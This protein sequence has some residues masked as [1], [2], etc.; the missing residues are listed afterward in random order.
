MGFKAPRAWSH[1]TTEVGGYGD[2]ARGVFSR[3]GFWSSPIGTAGCKSCWVPDLESWNA[4]VTLDLAALAM[5]ALAAL[6][7]TE[8]L[9][10]LP[11]SSFSLLGGKPKAPVSIDDDAFLDHLENG[12]LRESVTQECLTPRPA[13]HWGEY[14]L[15]RIG[16]DQFKYGSSN[17][18]ACCWSGPWLVRGHRPACDACYPAT[19]HL[20]SEHTHTL[21]TECTRRRRTRRARWRSASS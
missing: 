13:K 3:V 7:V 21:T 4:A 11:P 15:K 17:T 20:C 18:L 8:P 16:K 19:D 12:Y 10:W 1:T 5:P 6:D 9:N 14:C 2:V